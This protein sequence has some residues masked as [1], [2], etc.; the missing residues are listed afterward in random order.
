[1]GLNCKLSDITKEPNFR[2]EFFLFVFNNQKLHQIMCDPSGVVGSGVSF[3]FLQIC[4]PFRVVTYYPFW[5]N[6]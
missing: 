2:I 3:V 6:S 4:D 1:M 5:N